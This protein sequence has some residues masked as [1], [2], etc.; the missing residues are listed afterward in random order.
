MDLEFPWS[1]HWRLED[2]ELDTWK[3]Y[4]PR[5]VVFAATA[6]IHPNGCAVNWRQEPV[7]LVLHD[8]LHDNGINVGDSPLPMGADVII[9]LAFRLAQYPLRNYEF[10]G[11]LDPEF[12]MARAGVY[13]LDPYQ[14][15]KIPVVLIHGVWSSPKVWAP[16]LATLRADPALR[17]AYQFWVVLYPSGYALPLAACSVRRVAAR[18]PPKI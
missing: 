8:P 15:G 13:A 3:P 11:V 5:N 7:E 10:L 16:M 18:N 12:Y 1:A 4:G 14:P 17:A 2:S 6:V 9:P